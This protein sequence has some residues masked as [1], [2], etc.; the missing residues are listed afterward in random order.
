M[1]E[2]F[3]ALEEAIMEK[4]L[5]GEEKLCQYYDFNIKTRCL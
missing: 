4:L 3:L 1:E 5:Y 2:E